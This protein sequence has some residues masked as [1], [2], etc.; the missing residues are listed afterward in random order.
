MQLHKFV[1]TR[2]YYLRR[3]LL[4]ILYQTY[5]NK[6]ALRLLSNLKA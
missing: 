5:I 2:L 1:S 6:F 3:I 4:C